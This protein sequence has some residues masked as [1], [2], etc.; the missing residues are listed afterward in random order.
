MKL[1]PPAPSL[2]RQRLVRRARTLALALPLAAGLLLAGCA[3][4]SEEQLI[5]S[6]RGF[7][8]KNDHKAAVIQLKNALQKNNDAVEARLLLGQAMLKLGDPVSAAVELGK[9]RDLGAPADQVAPDLARALLLTGQDHRVIEQFAE[10]QLNAAPARAE[11]ATHLATAYMVQNKLDRSAQAVQAALDA[12]PTHAPALVLRARMTAANGDLPAAHTIVDEV[13]QR[14]P[15]QLDAGLFKAE[16]LR[17]KLDLEGAQKVLEATLASNPESIGTHS[18]LAAVQ[19][20][21]GRMDPARKTIDG[22]RRI[23]PG[24][25]DTLFFDAQL[26]YDAND[27]ARTRQ[28]ADQVLKMVPN[29]IRTLELAAA[30]EYRRGD[31]TQAELFLNQALRLSPGQLLARHMLTQ[32]HLR[33]G[34]PERALETLKP[35]LEAPTVSASTLALAGEAYLL[36]GDTRRSEEAFAAA[37]RMVP[38][39]VRLRTSLAVSQ[40]ARSNGGEQAMQALEKLATEDENPRADL[41]LISGHLA[42]QDFAAA[43]KA[44]EGLQ[45]KQPDRALPDYVRGRI[46]VQQKDEAGARA[47]FEAALKKEVRFLPAATSLAAMDLAAG[48]GDA[49]RQ[50]LQAQVQA[51]P[52]SA[53]THLALAEV[54]SRLGGTAAEVTQLLGNAVRA[55]GNEPRAHVA[56]V[57]HLLTTGDT[58]AALTAAQAGAA[59]LPTDATVMDALGRAQQANGDTQQALSTWRTLATQQPRQPQPHLRM[60][61]LL[62]GER[63]WDEAERSLRRALDLQPDLLAAERGLVTLAL[64]R[65]QPE[66]GLPVARSLQQR[67]PKEA[68]GWLLEGDVEATR[69]NQA[70]AL[71]AYR[72]GLQRG[73]STEAAIRL[74]RQLQ[75]GGQTAEADSF[76]RDWQKA[77]PRD[78]TFRYYLGD[79]ALAR[80]DWPAAEA[81]YRAVLEAAP[82]NALAMNNIAWLLATQKKEGAVAMARRAIELAPGRAPLLDTLALALATEGQLPQALEAQRQALAQ[83]PAD[84]ALKLTLAKLYIQTGDKPAARKLLDELESLGTRYAGQ[85]EVREL[86]QQAR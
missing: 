74:H 7:L 54:V 8:A 23:A 25:P 52:A 24:H 4:E 79:S 83:A 21:L 6:A 34:Q 60:A 33:T 3:G 71:A 17:A 62:A 19:L 85:A 28:L 77:Q 37:S 13:L 26:A 48:R 59:A 43:L 2:P 32:T 68:I 80:K 27:Y 38:D 36:A 18:A 81:H 55:N 35:L 72:A 5:A 10:T 11:L 47:S 65:G 14:E 61:E 84:P 53:A 22:L 29:S 20:V 39:D 78:A 76:A 46:L 64:Q 82:D 69:K 86:R 56:L 45:K 75:L 73:N 66:T 57:S 9:A 41:A 44:L 63:K 70:A 49:A 40:L 42:K 16:L 67:Y 58:R 51:D 30:A 50:R 12:V 1:P 15:G 31:Y